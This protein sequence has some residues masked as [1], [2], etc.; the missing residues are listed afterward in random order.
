MLKKYLSEK[1]ISI[2]SLSKK[3]GI[4]YSTLN[5]IA[6]ARVSIDNVKFG[7]VRSIAEELGVTL[8]ELYKICEQNMDVLSEYYGIKGRIL[9]RDKRF[10]IEY[11][12]RNKK[13]EDYVALIKKDSEK[14]IDSMALWVMEEGIANHEMEEAYALLSKTS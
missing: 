5:D 11:T 10:Y 3:L 4:P 9:R 1:K 7:L 8:E 6:N 14:Y 12:F 2:Y 13:Y